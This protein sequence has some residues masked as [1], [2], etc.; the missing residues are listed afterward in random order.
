MK[1]LITIT[2]ALVALFALLTNSAMAELY[3]SCAVVMIVDRDS[4]IV[5]FKDIMGR[6]WKMRGCEDWHPLDFAAL[7][8]DDNGTSFVKDDRIV[9]ATYQM[10]VEDWA[11]RFPYQWGIVED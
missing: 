5:L 6:S 7:L 11:K 8:M 2:I 1:K 4:N 9:R 10:A 3:P